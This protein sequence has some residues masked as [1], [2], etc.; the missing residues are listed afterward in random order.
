M[1]EQRALLRSINRLLRRHSAAE[2]ITAILDIHHAR[3]AAA[4]MRA[5]PTETNERLARAILRRMAE[6]TRHV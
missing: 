5:Y 2:L 4:A 3:A 6:E 1:N